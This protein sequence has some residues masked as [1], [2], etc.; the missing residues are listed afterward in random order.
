V[1]ITT[2]SQCTSTSSCLL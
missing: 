1:L 2:I